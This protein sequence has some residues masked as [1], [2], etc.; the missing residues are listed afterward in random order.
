[1]NDRLRA[2]WDFDDLDASE[3]RFRAQLDEEATPSGQA[4]VLTQLARVEGLRGDFDAGERL[5][6]EAGSLVGASPV[7]G[8]RVDLER[9][10]LRRSR[11]DRTDALPLFETAFETAREAG[12]PFIAVDAAHMAALAAPDNA[13]FTAWTSRG[14]EIA[15]ATTEPSVRYWLGALLNNLGWQQFENGDL[16]AALASFERALGE[17]ERDPQNRQAIELALYAVAKTLR[18]LGR[19][20]EG[21][22]LLERAQASAATDDRTDPWVHEELA[23]TYAALGR[24]ADTREH[25]ER[26]LAL[27]PDADADFEADGERAARLRSMAAETAEAP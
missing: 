1:V 17:R 22:S 27:L 13:G 24:K 15:E 2:L 16:E 12:E 3:A 18:S 20:S 19:P 4:E 8:A 5:I 25:A 6:E 26:A 14:I 10:R 11:G 21:L 9:G 23:E 7:A